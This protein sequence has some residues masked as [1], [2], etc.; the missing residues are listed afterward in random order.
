VARAI[1]LGAGISQAD[2]AA[3]VEVARPS[4]ARWELG[5]REPQGETRKRY[6]EALRQLAAGLAEEQASV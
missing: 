6:A 1:R 2:L 4:V 3:V 5:T